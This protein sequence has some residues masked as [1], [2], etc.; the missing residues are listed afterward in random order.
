MTH[1]RNRTQAEPAALSSHRT[2]PSRLFSRGLTGG[3]VLFAVLLGIVAEASTVVRRPIS[4]GLFA[5]MRNGNQP[6]LEVHLPGGSAGKDLLATVLRTTADQDTYS[7]AKHVLIPFARLNADTRRTVLLTIFEDAYVDEEGWHHIV[8]FAG[9]EGKETL[10]SLAEWLTGRG[11]NH[12]A[13][14]SHNNMASANLEKGQYILVPRELLL[15]VM[16]EPTPGRSPPQQAP[17]LLPVEAIEPEQRAPE[18]PTDGAVQLARFDGNG[19][20][21]FDADQAQR[22]LTYEEDADGPYALYLI[23]PGEAIYSAV[24]VRFTNFDTNQAI[25]EASAIIAERSGITDVTD[26]DDFTPIKIPVDMLADRFKPLGDPARQ[27]YEASIA[28]SRRLR[29]EMRRDTAFTGDL[30]GVVVVL[31]P[32]HGSRDPG[33][34]QPAYGLYESEIAY[35][36]VSRIIQLL[37][38]TGARVYSTL[39]IPDRGFT[40]TDATRFQ[41]DRS[42]IVLTTPPY[43]DSPSQYDAR[44]SANLRYYIANEIFAKET[45]AGVDP[46]RI[47]FSSIHCDALFNTQH[48]G[49]FFYIPG[50]AIRAQQGHRDHTNAWPYRNFREVRAVSTTDAERRRDEALSRVFAQTLYEE[51]GEMRVQRFRHGPAIRTEIRRSRTNVFVPAVLHGNKIPT[52]VL[53]EIANMTNPTDRERMANPEWRQRVAQAYVNGLK[54]HFAAQN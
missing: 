54:T 8:Q 11:F 5:H 30:E 6:S 23:K 53:I 9:S 18:T 20:N 40:P 2:A 17:P 36:V 51:F 35:D 29:D 43:P 27:Q 12:H 44:V 42:G 34:I 31:D 26:I 22:E 39:V 21:S 19:G 32:G 13:I 24:V 7:S 25:M 28:E 48:R 38:P 4:E 16:R 14:Q 45:A 41:H 33:A 15:E 49:A 46:R 10:W 37:E 50:A 52:K 1:D 47:I 3:L